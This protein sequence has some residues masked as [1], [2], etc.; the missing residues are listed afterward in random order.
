MAVQV[1]TFD[2]LRDA[3]AALASDSDAHFLGGGTL[4]VRQLF[5]GKLGAPTL[6]RCS[7][8]GLR[9][10]RASASR[11]FIGAGVTMAEVAAHGDL[12]YLHVAAKSIGGPAVRNMATVGGNLFAPY[13]HGDFAVALLAL[14]ATVAVQS[15]YSPRDI[16]L[17]SFL[18]SRQSDRRSVVVGVTFRRPDGAGALRFLKATRTRTQGPSVLT[19]AAYLPQ[20][21]RRLS[22]PRVAYGA[23]AATA[24]RAK[25]V[26]A[27]L[28]GKSLDEAGIADALA[29]AGQG[30]TPQSDPIVSEWYRKEVLPVHLKQLL[31]G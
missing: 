26:E 23:M 27:A 17:E 11:V 7:D 14:D 24:M 3:T 6:I 4:L 13:P 2:Q 29:V 18:E 15:G 16:P 12:A 19:I 20:S 5:A 21:G 9:E 31:L 10:I 8:R 25:A 30:C 22:S 28:N 1:N